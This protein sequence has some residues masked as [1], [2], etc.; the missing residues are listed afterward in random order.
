MADVE[1]RQTPDRRVLPTRNEQGGRRATDADPSHGT[2]ARYQK[3][4]DCLPCRAAEASY[5][6]DLRKRH[7]K[8]LP[9]LG[10]H[11][12]A[13]EAWARIRTLKAEQFQ[14][15]TI[16]GWKDN[17]EPRM[18]AQ[19]RIR[20]STL[21]RLRQLCMAYLIEDADLPVHI[22]GPELPPTP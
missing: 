17:H 1:R 4:C 13:S 9:I 10:Q 22:H 12:N 5:R 19:S 18:T 8:S 14:N 15:R 3:G 16:T 2:R 21:V 11:I 6:A 20:L 7:A